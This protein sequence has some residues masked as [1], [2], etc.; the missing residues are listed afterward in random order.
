M[1]VCAGHRRTYVGA[2]PGKMVQCL[3]STG[4]SNPMV[5]ID[6]IDKLGRGALLHSDC[7]RCAVLCL[8]AM[9]CCACFATLYCT[10]SVAVRFYMCVLHAVT[11]CAVLSCAVLCC[12]AH[13]SLRLTCASHAPAVHAL[14]QTHCSAMCLR[15]QLS[16]VPSLFAGVS[17]PCSI[18]SQSIVHAPTL[19]LLFLPQYHFPWVHTC[20]LSG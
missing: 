1:C 3:K 4:T 16:V 12:A 7:L 19:H 20:R 11:C 14:L 10:V 17:L 18:L 9:L 6:E 5:L 8:H 15:L 2:M 13:C